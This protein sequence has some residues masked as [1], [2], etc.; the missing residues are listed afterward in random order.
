LNLRAAESDE[1]KGR[2]RPDSGPV[3]VLARELQ[4]ELARCHECD[5]T[6]LASPRS[7]QIEANL[8][9]DVVADDIGEF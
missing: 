8:L 5:I 9:A 2:N 6:P 4:E 3:C 1:T 7:N